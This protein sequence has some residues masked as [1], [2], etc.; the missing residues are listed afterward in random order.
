MLF[1]GIGLFSAIGPALPDLARN[2]GITLAEAGVLFSALY[3]GAV[4]M[5]MMAGQL[6]ERFGLRSVLVTGCI[7][8][9]LGIFGL[10][11]ST[12]LPFAIIAMLIAGLGD[13]VAIVVANVLVVQSFS[14]RR[15]AALNL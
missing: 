10:T 15:L 12:A 2:T 3:V 13:G 7:L 8:L 9:G 14:A 11:V 1:F 6:T 5:Q 4:S